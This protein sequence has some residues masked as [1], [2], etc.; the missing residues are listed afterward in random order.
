M[1]GKLRKNEIGR[2]EVVDESGNRLEL[3]SGDV[4]EVKVADHWIRTRIE[5]MS[6]DKP[7]F[8]AEYYAVVPG[9]K[10]YSGQP[11]RH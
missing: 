9:V 4:V 8:T 3:T 6:S 11:A 2:W 7:P 1:E 10:L 5:S